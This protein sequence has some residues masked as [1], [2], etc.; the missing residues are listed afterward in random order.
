MF[1][2]LSISRTIYQEKKI[3]RTL[4]YHTPVWLDD[5]IVI[6]K[7][8]K[9]KQSLKLITNLE[10]LQRVGHRASEKRSNCF[11]TVATWLGHEFNAQGMKANKEKIEVILQLKAPTSS[12]ELK[13]TLGALQDCAKLLSEQL[14]VTDWI[15][16][17]RE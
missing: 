9:G 6:A 12:N 3:D 13:S 15:G 2:G 10:K 11:P 1:Y 16:N 17:H 14:N 8:D 5:I 4:N 7:R